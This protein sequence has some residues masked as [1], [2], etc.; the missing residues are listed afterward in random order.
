MGSAATSNA[1][2][3]RFFNCAL[4][5]AR[6][7]TFTQATN[8]HW[9]SRSSAGLALTSTTTALLP[10]TPVRGRRGVDSAAVGDSAVSSTAPFLG[11]LERLPPTPGVLRRRIGPRPRRSRHFSPRIAVEGDLRAKKTI[12]RG[13]GATHKR[14]R[15]IWEPRVAAGY[16]ACARCRRLIV[17]GEPWDLGHADNDRSQCAGPEHR[18]CNRSTASRRPARRRGGVPIDDPDAG[19]FWGP[20]DASGNYARWSRAW[21][22][23]RS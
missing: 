22:E 1:E 21:F 17:P 23:W 13:Y 19:V 12:E 5:F 7:R 20:P 2:S 9:S 18:R 3:S 4:A 14:L 6:R 11:E 8:S 16:V 10:Q 15:R